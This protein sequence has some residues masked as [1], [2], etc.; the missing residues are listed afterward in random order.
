MIAARASQSR[1]TNRF[2]GILLGTLPLRS[3]AVVGAGVSGWL[4]AATLRRVL[5][6]DCA[7]TVASLPDDN[8]ISGAL[9]AAPSFHRLLG[10]LGADERALLRDTDGTFRLGTLFHGWG[11]PKQQYFQG[12]GS[13]GAKLDGVPFQHHWLRAASAGGAAAFE[14]FSMAAQLAKL[15]RF[16]TPHNDPRSVLSLFSYGW[17]FDS[18]L[19]ASALRAFALQLGVTERGG[20]L[21]DVELD[22]AGDIRAV[23]IGGE[24]VAAEFFVDCSGASAALARPLG[25]AFED[26]SAWLPCD[27]MQWTRADAAGSLRPYTGIEAQASGWSFSLPLQRHTV[28]GWV[29]ASEYTSDAEIAAL[30]ARVS[31]TPPGVRTLL[32]GRP[33]E[34]WVRNCLLLPGEALEPLESAGL[35]LAQTGITRWLAH[36]PAHAD[37]PTDRGEYNRLTAEEYDRILDLMALHYHAT[38]RDD[39]P[40]W[41]R[42]RAMEPPATLAHR[43]ELFADSARL[44]IGEE[45]HCG[46][47]GWLAV[48]L[49]QGIEPRSYDPLAEATPLPVARDALAKMA[50]DMQAR[51]QAAPMQRDFLARNGLLATPGP[52]SAA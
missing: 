8:A 18:K 12:F 35:H 14:D 25:A 22:T 41:R 50:A 26:W 30:L 48:L 33:R 51:A 46:A 39:S 52:R 37:S 38:T 20:P 45:E 6:E 29:Y 44:T 27:R 3:I 17:H 16:A 13:I 28:R 40:F 36:F 23:R 43:V 24:R 7:V 19:L 49:G 10:L 42:C 4:A 34:F 21:S 31:S 2:G 11:A 32:R 9:A 5:G 1:G 15:D 47:D